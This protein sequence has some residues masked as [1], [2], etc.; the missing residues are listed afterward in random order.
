MKLY[1]ND[2]L[3]SGNIK[4][5]DSFITKLI[6]LL[7]KK[8]LDKNEGLLLTNCS[9][10]HCFF[11]KFTI[12]AVYLSKDMKVIYKETVKPWRTGKFVR[13]CTHILELPEGMA[14]DIE[15]GDYISLL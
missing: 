2:K 13:N 3:L 15:I 9:G 10:I 7:N 4:S 12:D 6:G 5:A 1:V 11:M 8:S 14:K